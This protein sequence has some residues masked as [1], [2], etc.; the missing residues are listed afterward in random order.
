METARYNLSLVDLSDLLGVS[1]QAI[2]Q[3]VP[4]FQPQ[5]GATSKQGK[6]PTSLSPFSVR[7][8]LESKGY[9]YQKR[10]IAFQVIKGGVGKTT[11]AKNFGIRAA[12]YGYKV[13][14]IDFDHQANLTFA[15][16]QFN[17]SNKVWLHLIRGSVQNVQS[18]VKPI[19]ETISIIPSAL[20]NARMDSEL[21]TNTH[22]LKSVVAKPMNELKNEYD[23]IVCDC[24][25]ALGALVSSVYLAVDQVIAPVIPDK[26]S[27]MSIEFM[28]EEWKILSSRF[29]FTPDIKLLINRH[30]PRLK[31]SNEQLLHLVSRYR[32]WMLPTTVRA[33]AD[34]L[35]TTNARSHLW[36]IKRASPAAEDVDLMVRHV[37]N[38][39]ELTP[40]NGRESDSANIEAQ[41]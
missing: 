8:I 14:F 41:G 7:K 9:K 18:L 30:D 4:K 37:L 34:F 38:L 40:D 27:E 29:E 33:S 26:F 21:L 35:A 20:V 3:I 25:P 5:Q 12:Q 31:S 13:L 24:P 19:S 15:L 2:H 28:M 6:A 1:R 23:L 16:D 36:E 22:N 39:S 10:T 17:P 11:L 32:D